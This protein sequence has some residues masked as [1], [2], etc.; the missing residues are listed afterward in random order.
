LQQALGIELRQSSQ[1]GSIVKLAGV[2]KVGA[3]TAGLGLEFTE[4]Q[5]ATI[6]NKLQE[7]LGQRILRRG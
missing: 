3:D 1:L 7:I 2:E 6:H 5:H 4:P